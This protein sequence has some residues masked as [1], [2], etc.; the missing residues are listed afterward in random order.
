MF[1]PLPSPELRIPSPVQPRHPPQLSPETL[2]RLAR[3]SRVSQHKYLIL[4]M[5]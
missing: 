4:L 3:R 1:Q 2:P 5:R